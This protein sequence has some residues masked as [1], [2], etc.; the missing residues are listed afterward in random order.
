MEAMKQGEELQASPHLEP[1][2]VGQ[3]KALALPSQQSPRSCHRPPISPQP[4]SCS[5]SLK[6]LISQLC[7]SKLSWLSAQFISSSHSGAKC[8]Y[9]YCNYFPISIAQG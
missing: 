1:H 5:R 3:V 8:L 6:P 9:Y 4:H 2:G 7:P